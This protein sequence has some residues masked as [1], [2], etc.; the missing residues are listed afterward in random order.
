MI[1]CSCEIGCIFVGAIHRQVPGF[2]PRYKDA[3]VY[4]E[5]KAREAVHRGGCEEAFAGESVYTE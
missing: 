3:W 2:R 5:Q 4:T 1:V